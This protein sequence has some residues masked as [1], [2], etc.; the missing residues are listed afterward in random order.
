MKELDSIFRFKRSK[1]EK[2][3][4]DEVEDRMIAF[5]KRLETIMK[6]DMEQQVLLE[7]LKKSCKSLKIL[8][9][10]NQGWKNGKVI[11][12]ILVV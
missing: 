11:R 7:C 6:V 5:Q 2:K 9:W 12:I 3:D 1:N 4:E 10:H 8:S